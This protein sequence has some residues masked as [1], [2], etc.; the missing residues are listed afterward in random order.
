[1]AIPCYT[2]P[3]YTEPVWHASNRTRCLES[4][5]GKMLP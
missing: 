2:E 3:G 4:G 5:T 1:M